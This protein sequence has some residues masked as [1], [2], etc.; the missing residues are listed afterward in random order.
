VFRG[1]F[2][3]SIDDKGRIIVPAKFRVQLGEKFVIT[4]GMG[5]CLIVVTENE[6]RVN[7]EEKFQALSPFNKNSMTLQRFFCGE[8]LDTSVDSQGRV[9]ISANLRK[10]AGINLQS[11]VMIIGVGNRLEMWSKE[12]WDSLNETTTEDDLSAC[13]EAIGVGWG[14]ESND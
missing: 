14:G 4:K 2:E 12:R 13:I 8:A 9:A 3:H 5:G 1:G 11:D 7:F 6:F 10:W